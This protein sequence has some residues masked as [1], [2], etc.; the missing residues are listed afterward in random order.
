MDKINITPRP[1]HPRETPTPPHPT[2]SPFTCRLGGP[3]SQSGQSGKEKNFLSRPGF[4]LCP[5]SSHSGS[6]C[7]DIMVCYLFICISGMSRRCKI[8]WRH[9]VRWL[10]DWRKR[11]LNWTECD[12]RVVLLVCRPKNR[13]EAHTVNV[14]TAIEAGKLP[15]TLRSAAR[16]DATICSVFPLTGSRC[17]HSSASLRL[18]TQLWNPHPHALAFRTPNKSHWSHWLPF[19]HIIFTK[20]SSGI[21]PNV[22]F[23]PASDLSDPTWPLFIQSL[24][25]ALDLTPIHGTSS[26][27]T[28][29][30]Y[31]VS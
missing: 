2:P 19:A 22:Q 8:L 29:G 5:S 7:Y 3:Q 30:Y 10:D 31:R 14:L 11:T 25:A 20:C 15:N 23:S 17:T 16:R 13:T 12:R 6:S 24:P 28:T 26:D 27:H 18:T 9:G 1:L 21:R 4:K